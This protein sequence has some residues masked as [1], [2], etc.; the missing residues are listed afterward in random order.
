VKRATLSLMDTPRTQDGPSFTIKEYV[1][2]EEGSNL[3]HEYFDG[4]IRLMSGGTYEH[5]RLAAALIMQLGSQLRGRE[6][7]VFTCDARVHVVSVGM[8]TYPDVTICC[9]APRDGG[10]DPNAMVN[11]TVI[12][13]V[14]SDST[15][16]YDRGTK[17]ARYKLVDSL[18]EYVLVSHREQAIEIFRRLDDGWSAAHVYR[19]GERAKLTSVACEIDVDEL[20]R[21]RLNY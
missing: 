10:D 9:G 21:D 13:E 12:I 7:R 2:L 6:C 11:P 16:K 4:Q 5:S 18:R 14:L 8:I 1:E 17:F 3:R 15:E 19:A 20:Y